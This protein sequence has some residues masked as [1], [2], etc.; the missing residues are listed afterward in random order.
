MN[1][2]IR[3]SGKYVSYREIFLCPYEDRL[4]ALCV[5][6]VFGF[7]WLINMLVGIVLDVGYEYDIQAALI[8][9]IMAVN[10]AISVKN[11]NIW[12]DFVTFAIMSM[13][14]Y[15]LLFDCP[16]GPDRNCFNS[17]FLPQPLSAP[18]SGARRTGQDARSKAGGSGMLRTT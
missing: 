3:K 14:V 6:L 15:S 10:I 5:K 8:V 7:V 17:R 18:E 16:G 11:Y 1:M 4:L 9:L 2:K 13:P 12:I